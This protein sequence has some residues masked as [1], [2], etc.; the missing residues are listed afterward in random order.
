[1]VERATWSGGGALRGK[2]RMECTGRGKPQRM[3]ER[4]IFDTTKKE[5]NGVWLDKSAKRKRMRN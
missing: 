1:M 4:T 2:E 3:N 5:R